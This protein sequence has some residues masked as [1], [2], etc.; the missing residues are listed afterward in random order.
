MFL[1]IQLNKNCIYLNKNNNSNIVK[2]EILF[3]S[4][5][6]IWCSRSISDYYQCWKQLW[7]Y[8]HFCGKHDIYCF[9][10]WVL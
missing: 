2:S 1:N 7:C 3:H 9:L 10:Y 8:T 4:D 5:M 6:L